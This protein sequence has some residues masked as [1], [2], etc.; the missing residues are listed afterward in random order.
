MSSSYP[1]PPP[2]VGSL[3]RAFINPARLDSSDDT[4]EDEIE[5]PSSIEPQ[6]NF[7]A[8][9]PSEG[10]PLPSLN[11]M[12]ELH[13][14]K[15]S[16]LPESTA[17][18]PRS[19]GTTSKETTPVM[20]SHSTSQPS[21]PRKESSPPRRTKSQDDVSK[22]AHRVR[23]LVDEEFRRGSEGSSGRGVS[24][25]AAIS[26]KNKSGMEESR[27]RAKLKRDSRSPSS[28]SGNEGTVGDRSSSCK[29]ESTASPSPVHV[30]SLPQIK[31]RRPTDPAVEQF[32][33]EPQNIEKDNVFEKSTGNSKGPTSSREENTPTNT[34]V[35][36]DFKK[37]SVVDKADSLIYST[38]EFSKTPKKTVELFAKVTPKKT[39]TIS[40]IPRDTTV[41]HYSQVDFTKTKPK[42]V[43]KDDPEP[44]EFVKVKTGKVAT[45]TTIT[46]PKTPRRMTTITEETSPPVPRR[47][48][49]PQADTANQSPV[50]TETNPRIPTRSAS[51]K[52]KELSEN[53]TPPPLSARVVPPIPA[54]SA[55]TTKPSTVPRTLPSVTTPPTTPPVPRARGR[56]PSDETKPP[57]PLKES[58]SK[59]TVP[60]LPSK[61]NTT[62]PRPPLPP[63]EENSPKPPLPMKEDTRASPK[64]P[65]PPLPAKDDSPGKPPL[66]AKDKVLDMPPLPPKEDSFEKLNVSSLSRTGNTRS[67]ISNKTVMGNLLEEIRKKQTRVQPISQEPETNTQEPSKIDPS[68]LSSS[69]FS[70]PEAK[71]SP[72]NSPLR[73]R[74]AA[75]TTRMMKSR[76]ESGEDATSLSIA[77]DDLPDEE[78]QFQFRRRSSAVRRGRPR[79]IHSMPDTTT[80]E[81]QLP[82]MSRARTRSSA[83]SGMER[84]VR[85]G[86]RSPDMRR[87][88][89]EDVP[90]P[91]SHSA[92]PDGE[93]LTKL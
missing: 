4:D 45:A 47:R 19:F 66:P 33:P 18:L 1:P 62:V 36:T 91:Q 40:D 23:K 11:F 28:A 29:E 15:D 10:S 38:V 48:R 79:A 41:V 5:V 49:E 51:L 61:D 42:P 37:V 71:K 65:L 7:T 13:P 80:P 54:E 58:S 57:L 50:D 81:P 73:R 67:T 72:G 90:R 84:P 60:P 64:I 82:E 86:G 68:K 25:R 92:A 59:R 89:G 2:S 74:N 3:P 44:D 53:E 87:P 77:G 85:R 9:Q 20:R 56:K 75:R 31:L 88:S 27:R 12:K 30:P 34:P 69:D 24:R 93:R 16:S 17:T 39:A 46:D 8:K 63:K 70:S 78:N 76:P 83:V 35:K 43:I 6:L 21:P 22:D 26:S 32:F 52:K 14:R 55:E